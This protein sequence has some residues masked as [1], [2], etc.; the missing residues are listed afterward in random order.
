[1]ATFTGYRQVSM[2]ENLTTWYGYI[3]Q[4][5]SNLIVISD[6]YRASYYTGNSFVY[7]GNDVVGGTLTGY[8]LVLGNVTQYSVYDFSY[9]AASAGYLI[10]SNQASKLETN[11][12]SGEDN[13]F[14]SSLSDSLYGFGGNDSIKGGAGNDYIDGS[15]GYNTSVY[16]ST[17]SN[18]TLSVSNAGTMVQDRSGT[19]GTDTLVS[20]QNLQ[21]S[22]TSLQNS[23]FT[24][25]LNLTTSNPSQFKVMTEMYLAYFNRAPDAVGLCYWAAGSYEG[26]S[27]IQISNTF[28]STPEFI[29]T[30]GS[31]SSQSSSLAL[32]NF[33]AA[34]YENVLDRPAEQGGLNFWLNGLQTNQVTPG[35][36]ILSV[37]EAVNGQTGTTDSIYFS[38]KTTVATH[39]AVTDGL[40]NTTQAIAVMNLFNSTYQASGITT[41]VTAANALSDQYLAHVATTPELVIHLTGIIGLV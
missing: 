24:G 34:V 15:S 18:Y 9:S 37:I 26:S 13:I 5:T 32:S 7:S 29:R 3:Y 17:L 38:N 8:S 31:I 35:N 4:A 10:N 12:L 40:T 22:N 21:F 41:A 23:W 2:G 39:F 14:G 1:M 30:Y 27:N 16:I 33:V 19:D 11:I 28:A 20:I 6:G 25:A 36:L